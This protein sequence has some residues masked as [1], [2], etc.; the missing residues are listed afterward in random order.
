M[1]KLKDNQE[2]LNSVM[3]KQNIRI[4][5]VS[6]NGNQQFLQYYIDNNKLS[7]L[8]PIQIILNSI[9]DRQT[10]SI[11]ISGVSS[12]ENSDLSNY[13]GNVS[14]SDSNGENIIV[15]YDGNITVGNNNSSLTI[16]ATDVLYNGNGINTPNGFVT[17]NSNGKIDNDF[18]DLQFD[19]KK[20][21]VVQDAF[22][23]PAE[24][25]QIT[26]K[27]NDGVYRAITLQQLSQLFAPQLQ[28]V[29]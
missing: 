3:D 7:E 14:I 19:P 23:L 5:G 4:K 11:C 28:I 25:V 8:L 9:F 17:L 29:Y 10:S 18:I 15:S 22:S 12:Q 21:T 2:I 1:Q 26:I 20:L 6:K 13:S 24:Q 27:D 16:N